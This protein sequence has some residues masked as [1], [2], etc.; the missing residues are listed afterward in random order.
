M[1]R[2]WGTVKDGLD[3]ADNGGVTEDLHDLGVLIDSSCPLVLAETRE[4]R[5]CLETIRETARHRDLP[6]WTWSSTRG[7]QRDGGAAQYNTEEL[8]QALQ[9]IASLEQPAVYVLADAHHHYADPGQARLLKETVEAIADRSTI[10]VTAPEHEVPAGLEAIASVWRQKPPNG[11]ELQSL[12]LRTIDDLKGRGYRVQLDAVGVE[13]MAR[14]LRGLP[15]AR[16]ERLVR[17]ETVTDGSLDD[18]DVA[19]LRA[20]RAALFADDGV[21]ELVDPDG[22]SLG[23]LA[24]IDEL[25]DWLRLRGKVL[26]DPV[27][28]LPAPRGVLLTGVPG[29]GKSAVAKALADTW[30]LPLVLLDPGALF[31]KWVGGS[32][33]RLRQALDAA[34]AMSPAVLWIDEVEKGFA[35]SNDQDGGVGRRVF[36]TFLRWLQDRPDG[37]FVIATANDVTSL[38]P[39]FFRKG[40]VDEVFFLDLPDTTARQAILEVHL[41]RRG[42][43]P[44]GYPLEQ[45]A[46]GT[47]GFSGSELEAAVVAGMYRALE[48]PGTLTPR[49]LADELARTVPLAASRAEDIHD[50][51]QWARGRTRSAASLSPVA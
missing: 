9:T 20:A 50:L 40:R 36:G 32:E 26:A 11:A 6:V 44:E 3:R 30:E 1:V 21:L 45:L 29:C 37:V 19:R 51:R 7:L 24:G 46:E 42:H 18:A 22:P 2:P 5:R 16:A 15:V 13:R 49:L 38:P 33:A 8:G 17:K 31:D 10:V 39:E 35:G 28:G 48:G 41:R 23:E 27:E 12:V 34:E 43:N 47:A 25:S 14:A 4:E